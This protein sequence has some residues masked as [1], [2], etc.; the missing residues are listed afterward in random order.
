M[1]DNQLLSVKSTTLP[2]NE[3]EPQFFN[4]VLQL[5]SDDVAQ[6]SYTIAKL[7]YNVGEHQSALKYLDKFDE[8]R[9]GLLWLIIKW[10]KIIEILNL[11]IPL[12]SVKVSTTMIIYFNTLNAVGPKE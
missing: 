6:K 11:T 7:Y 8:V 1:S 3:L 9:I 10:V 2:P 5:S 12:Q 4:F